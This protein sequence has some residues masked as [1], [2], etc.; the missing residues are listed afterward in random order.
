[1]TDE[2]RQK[3]VGKRLTLSQTCCGLGGA[4]S[5]PGQLSFLCGNMNVREK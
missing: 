2:A 5:K 4:P 1:M 3:R